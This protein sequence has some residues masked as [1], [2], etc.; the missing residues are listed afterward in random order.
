[1][2]KLNSTGFRLFPVGTHVYSYSKARQGTDSQWNKLDRKMH[3]QCGPPEVRPA[4]EIQAIHRIQNVFRSSRSPTKLNFYL[5]G[6][7]LGGPLASMVTS[8]GRSL[9]SARNCFLIITAVRSSC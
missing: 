2:V 1:M 3:A 7:R 9:Y 4:S 8:P 5:K 6:E